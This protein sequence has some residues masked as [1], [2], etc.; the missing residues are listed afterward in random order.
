MCYDDNRSEFTKPVTPNVEKVA[1]Y[2]RQRPVRVFRHADVRLYK[3]SRELIE[4]EATKEIEATQA[5]RIGLPKREKKKIKAAI[6]KQ[7]SII[8]LAIYLISSGLLGLGRRQMAELVKKIL[9]RT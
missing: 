7:I 5:S 1:G 3:G 2:L 4:E 9:Q 8:Y 6:K